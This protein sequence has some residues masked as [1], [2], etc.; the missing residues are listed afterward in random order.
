MDQRPRVVFMG[1]P[2]FAVP[3]LRGLAEICEIVGVVTQ[4][5]KPAGRGMKLTP[6]AVKIVATELGIPL[7]QPRSLKEECA[8]NQLR[9]WSPDLIVVVAFGQLLRK[10]VLDLPRFG[11]LNVHASLLPAYRGAAPIQAAL[12]NGDQKTGVTIMRMDEGLDTGPIIFAAE[13]PISPDETAGTLSVKLSRLGAET[14]LEI[15]PDFLTGKL[16]PKA[17]PAQGT[18][19]FGMIRKE[20]GQLLTNLDVIL[21]ERKIRAF[22][23]WP[24]A[25]LQ[26]GD[27]TIKIHQAHIISGNPLPG[28]REIRDGYPAL[29]F[30]GGWLSLTNLQPAGRKAMDGKAFLAGKRD[31]VNG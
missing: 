30:K 27:E 17:Q 26:I 24:G 29:G 3:S 10:N 25:S 2:E 23:P 11:C 4:P 6:P 14:L 16:K 12:L 1:S 13:L 22:N 19:Y 8:F 21:A 15:L 31:W 9:E 18:S 28:S 20:D 5:D 7:I